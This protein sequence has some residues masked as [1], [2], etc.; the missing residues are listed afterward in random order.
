MYKTFNEV[1]KSFVSIV[2][3]IDNAEIL[4]TDNV[5]KKL[6]I[7]IR[8]II[9]TSCTYP[10]H[11]YQFIFRYSYSISICRIY[12]IYYC[13]RV[14]IITSPVGPGN[15]NN[16]ILICYTALTNTMYSL[17]HCPQKAGNYN[18]VSIRMTQE[19]YHS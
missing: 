2:S 6:L 16:N 10:Q 11:M 5:L 14:P 18:T 4:P 15:N 17:L 9:H 13:I 19:Q 3:F 1:S 8:N 7:N 12:Y